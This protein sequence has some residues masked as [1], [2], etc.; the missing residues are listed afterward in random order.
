MGILREILSHK[1][2]HLQ[3]RYAAVTSLMSK[4]L[5]VMLWAYWWLKSPTGKKIWRNMSGSFMPM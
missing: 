5:K 4:L 1:Y 2:L 3:S